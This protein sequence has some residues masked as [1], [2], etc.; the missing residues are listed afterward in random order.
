MKPGIEVLEDLLSFFESSPDFISVPCEKMRRTH[1]PNFKL[2]TVKAI[3]NLRTDFTKDERAQALKNCEDILD[4]FK[5]NPQYDTLV[6]SS[7]GIFSALDTTQAEAAAKQQEQSENL[8]DDDEEHNVNE[9]GGDEFDMDGF[10]KEGGIIVEEAEEVEGVEEEKKDV[11]EEVAAAFYST[12]A[13][14]RMS[15]WLTYTS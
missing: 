14:E 4:D 15:G 1:G 3:L 5:K 2:A 9:D 11:V 12:E 10:L 6:Q 8:E 13:D 7:K